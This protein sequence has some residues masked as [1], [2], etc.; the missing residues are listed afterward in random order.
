MSWYLSSVKLIVQDNSS[1]A[2]QIIARLQPVSGGT[3]LQIFGY[4]DPVVKLSAIIVGTTDRSTLEGFTQSGSAYTLSTPY[5]GL[6][7]YVSSFTSKQRLGV[8]SQNIII[9][10]SHT[11]T[12]P[13]FDVE[14][15]L[16]A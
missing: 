1:S 4:E 7:Y 3:T 5:G 8:I 14:I 2:K 15:E 12:D 16:M 13:V 11:C 10:G 6:S 9:D